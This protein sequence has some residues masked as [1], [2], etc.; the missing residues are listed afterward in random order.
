M[1]F[2]KDLAF[3]TSYWHDKFGDPRS[4]GCLNLA[5]LD[6]RW[7]YFWATPDVPLGWSMVYGIVEAPGSMVRIR[8]RSVPAPPWMGYATRVYE[9]RAAQTP[10]LVP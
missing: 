8:S 1:F 10:P 5:P 7:L 2:A 4:H 9:A 6:A 3:H